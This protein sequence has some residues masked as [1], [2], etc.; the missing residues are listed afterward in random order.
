M[1]KEF[2]YRVIKPLYSQIGPEACSGPYYC[3]KSA[4]LYNWKFQITTTKY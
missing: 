4:S 3:C 1:R 2:N